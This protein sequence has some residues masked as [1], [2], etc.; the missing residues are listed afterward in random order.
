[1]GTGLRRSGPARPTRDASYSVSVRQV[2]ALLPRFFQTAPRGHRPCA[3]LALHPHQILGR[4]LSP[5]SCQTCSAH[6]SLW[7][8]NNG[9]HRDLEISHRT[10]DSHIPTSHPHPSDGREKGHRDGESDLVLTSIGRRIVAASATLRTGKNTCRQTAK[11]VDVDQCSVALGQLTSYQSVSSLLPASCPTRITHSSQSPVYGSIAVSGGLPLQH[12]RSDSLLP[13][14]LAEASPNHPEHILPKVVPLHR[15]RLEQEE[16]PP[17]GEMRPPHPLHT[18]SKRTT[19]KC[20]RRG[21]G[22]TRAPPGTGPWFNS[23][24]ASARR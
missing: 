4:G 15:V 16:P 23:H 11:V 3:S 8:P 22:T 6:T 2:A 18:S 13:L 9:F 5:P 24:L 17:Q 7:K 12:Y 14:G 10:R 19:I 21:N 1:M 20:S